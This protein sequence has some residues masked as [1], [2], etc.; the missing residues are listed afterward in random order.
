MWLANSMVAVAKSPFPY[1][2]FLRLILMWRF[3]VVGNSTLSC[4]KASWMWPSPQCSL[5]VQMSSRHRLR[6]P[7]LHL[8][9]P[10]PHPRS[11]R[12]ITS[13][14]S[15]NYKLL[16]LPCNPL[17]I[18]LPANTNQSRR[19]KGLHLILRLSVQDCL[20]RTE[21]KSGH[22][23]KLSS[24]FHPSSLNPEESTERAWVS[25]RTTGRWGKSCT[26]WC[27]STRE[28][29]LFLDNSGLGL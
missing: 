16:L 8:Y 15:S 1:N 3:S 18:I 7:L 21:G 28:C 29:D 24:R 6:S 23:C 25:K 2:C 27:C 17:P 22:L 20:K 14:H 19:H 26:F 9:P 13:A 12:P 5:W 10:T 4:V 11:E